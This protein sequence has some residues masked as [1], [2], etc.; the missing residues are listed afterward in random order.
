[1]GLSPDGRYLAFTAVGADGLTRVWIRSLETLEAQP[2][3]GT[4]GVNTFFW[5]PDSRFL[6]FGAAGKL[7]KIDI[8]GGPPLTLCDFSHQVL[9]GT[10]NAEGVIL[11]GSNLDGIQRVAATG[12]TAVSITAIDPSRSEIT[13]S[14]PTFLP[15]GRHFLY[16]RRSAH[17]ENSGV[18]AGSLDVAS[19]AQSPKQIQ[20]AEYSPAYAPPEASSSHGRLLFL[21]E[22]ALMAQPFD[23]RKL[24]TA[25]EAVVIAEQVNTNL[26]R[27]SFSVSA[28]GIL[29]Y[30]SDA[31]VASQLDWLDREGK[32]LGRA[33]GPG[34]FADVAL[35][36]DGGRVAHTEVTQGAI[37]QI[38]VLDLARGAN[39]RLSFAPEGCEAP[40][41]SPDGKRVAFSSYNRMGAPRAVYIK[42][43]S[44]SGSEEP[45]LRSNELTFLDD[46]SRDGR[47]LVYSAISS[48]SGRYRLMAIP[49]AA[50]GGDLK[51]IP[52]VNSNFSEV[53]GQVSPDSRWLAYASDVSGRYEIYVR[54]FPPG[55]GRTGQWL[56]STQGAAEP[57]WR[58]DGKE[59]F[60]VTA[61][62]KVMAVDV[63]LGSGQTA[64][65][66]G[67]P[68]ILFARPGWIR[69]TTIFPYDVTRDGKR[70]LVVERA[71][72][73]TSPPA[74]VVVNWQAGLRK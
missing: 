66:Y 57:R 3:A 70:F 54:P 29:A 36:P 16:L 72:G 23:E 69:S 33:G 6:A 13:H 52:L 4:E 61:D 46:W 10:W 7:K 60:F 37:H 64:F 25:G 19:G 11:F 42:D 56:V 31:D 32:E 40:V 49:A 45:V 74:T 50:A 34:N 44:N 26:S 68:H 14:Y 24:A 5:S 21:R 8:S 59:L 22:G 30:R 47:F 58:P 73:A 35:S 65:Q 53:Q 28:H 39:T 43:A 15:D 27:A 9:G 51:P 38:W 1:M 18:Y 55:D 20:A 41:W 17:R 67:A 12:G 71:S 62:A 48:Q 2:L 63:T